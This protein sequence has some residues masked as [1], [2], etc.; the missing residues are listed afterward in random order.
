[1]ASAGATIAALKKTL[2]EL[3]EKNLDEE[4]EVPSQA[5]DLMRNEL[6]KVQIQEK[7]ASSRYTAL[8]PHVIA[9]RRQVEET[10]KILA[11]EEARHSQSTRRLS[12]VHQA[13]QTELATASAAAAAHKAVA[14]TLK[15]QFESVQSKIRALNDNELLIGDL[16]RK[17]ELLEASYRDYAT[18]CE[19][20]RI[21]TALAAGSVSNVN[22]VQSPTFV[23]KPS[24]PMV[25]LM[26]VLALVLATMAS[27]LVALVSE[28]LDRSLRTAEQIEQELGI[29]V[30]FSA[31]RD[32]RHVLLQN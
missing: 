9:L 2:A 28:H 20:S 6:Y 29:P 17:T 30:L 19:Q 16:T 5:A 3:P 4:S 22:V 23:A 15:P 27:I 24:S 31:P 10:R 32:S 8:H 21:D 18:A 25:K 11:S 12:T 7:E 13:V 14:E 1:L 26:L